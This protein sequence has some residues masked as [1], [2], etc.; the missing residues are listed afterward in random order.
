[1]S[2][3]E[4]F[5]N[6]FAVSD[7]LVLTFLWVQALI[8]R[9]QG[10]DKWSIFQHAFS[11]DSTLSILDLHKSSEHI[12][13]CMFGQHMEN[14]WAFSPF[15]FFV[16][17]RFLKYGIWC[18]M[19]FGGGST[20]SAR[21]VAILIQKY[22]INLILRSLRNSN[23]TWCRQLGVEEKCLNYWTTMADWASSSIHG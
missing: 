1:M 9:R 23:L 19:W 5:W 16:D 14:V 18:I 2:H 7:F 12:E 20:E 11:S 21:V 22:F 6:G 13:W 4:C 17:Q 8:N 10:T 3:R 15:D